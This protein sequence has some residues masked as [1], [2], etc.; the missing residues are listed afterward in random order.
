MSRYLTNGNHRNPCLTRVKAI[1]T[2]ICS[3]PTHTT[4]LPWFWVKDSQYKFGRTPNLILPS[5]KRDMFVGFCFWGVV[6][7]RVFTGLD[8]CVHQVVPLRYIFGYFPQARYCSVGRPEVY[9]V[10]TV[11][12]PECAVY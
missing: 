7:K 2:T 9:T 1:C 10:Q 5:K 12:S 6:I 3:N 8:A 4:S 11:R